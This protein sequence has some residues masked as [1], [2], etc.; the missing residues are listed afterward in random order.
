MSFKFYVIQRSPGGYLGIK[1]CSQGGGGCTK[2]SWPT[3]RRTVTR[4]RVCDHGVGILGHGISLWMKNEYSQRG[5][6]VF[7]NDGGMRRRIWRNRSNNPERSDNAEPNKNGDERETAEGDAN[8]GWRKSDE[9]NIMQMLNDE[10]SKRMSTLAE[11]LGKTKDALKLEE[12]RQRALAPYRVSS[13]RYG[14]I[15]NSRYAVTLRKKIISASQDERRQPILIFGEPGLHKFNTASLIHFGSKDGRYPLVSID[16]SRLDND[17]SELLGRGARKGLLQWLPV[18]GTVILTN[19][20]KAL[21]EVLPLIRNAVAMASL[22]ASIDSDDDMEYDFESTE[23]NEMYRSYRSFPRIIMTAETRVPGLEKHAKSIQIPP[24]RVRPRDI[25]DL[26]YFHLRQISK[27]RGLGLVTLTPEA[28][29]Y[30][31]CTFLNMSLNESLTFIPMH[32]SESA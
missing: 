14:I 6:V 15:G 31:A 32:R 23:E 3:A 22:A 29:G 18:Q 9:D 1:P 16:C 28:C 27:Q 30:L 25:K 4:R 8:S 12:S 11:E 19:V 7:S 24:L 17:A 2:T 10:M 26:V 5:N 21:P 20:H 13:P